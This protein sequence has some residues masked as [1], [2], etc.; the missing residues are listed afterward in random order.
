MI[1]QGDGHTD[2]IVIQ[3]GVCRIRCRLSSY[4]HTGKIIIQGGLS[5]FEVDHTKRMIIQG[6]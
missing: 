6:R 4:D 1:I 5:H 3:G 2:R